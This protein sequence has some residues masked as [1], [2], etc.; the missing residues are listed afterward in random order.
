MLKLGR[1]T[2][3]VTFNRKFPIHQGQIVVCVIEKDQKIER[4]TPQFEV[5]VTKVC[6]SHLKPTLSLLNEFFVLTKVPLLV[7]GLSLGSLKNNKSFPFKSPPHSLPLRH[8]EEAQIQTYN[9]FAKGS[10]KKTRI[11]YGRADRNGST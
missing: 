8:F 2:A 5:V 7:I 6:S 3:A 9:P 4:V 10:R 11:F 1:N